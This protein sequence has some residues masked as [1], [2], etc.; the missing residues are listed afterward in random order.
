MQPLQA[1]RL[2][3][4]ANLPPYGRSY[5]RILV[6]APLLHLP[7]RLQQ[8]PAMLEEA[9]PIAVG[10]G[11]ALLPALAFGGVAAA[12]AFIYLGAGEGCSTSTCST[13]SSSSTEAAVPLLVAAR[14]QNTLHKALREFADNHCSSCILPQLIKVAALPYC[15]WQPVVM[16]RWQ[17]AVLA[18]CMQG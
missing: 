10:V 13:S 4:P 3:V 2:H 9:L 8:L 16:Y 14:F 18:F 1:L 11:A 15:Q 17:C 6:H 5:K 7:C 12:R